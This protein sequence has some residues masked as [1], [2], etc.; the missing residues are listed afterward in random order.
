MLVRWPLTVLDHQP[1]IVEIE[2]INV[3]KP[4][5]SKAYYGKLFG[6]PNSFV[7][8]A[9]STFSLYVNVLVPFVEGPRK[10]VVV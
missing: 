2:K 4:E 10:N 5:V 8:K 9:S 1:R 3:S 7:I 6:K